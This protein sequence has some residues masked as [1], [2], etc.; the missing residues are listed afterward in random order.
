MNPSALRP[1]A[2]YSPSVR[3]ILRRRGQA[4]PGAPALR[5]VETSDRMALHTNQDS[6]RDSPK[7][8]QFGAAEARTPMHVDASSL[9]PNG[10]IAAESLV[11]TPAASRTET[12]GAPSAFQSLF[13]AQERHID[14]L[15]AETLSLHG[16]TLEQQRAKRALIE[17]SIDEKRELEQNIGELG[18]R[19]AALTREQR[20]LRD[21]RAEI[22][23]QAEAER[24]RRQDGL[25]LSEAQLRDAAARRAELEQLKRANEE[26]N[27]VLAQEKKKVSDEKK[28]LE[29]KLE[30]VEEGLRSSHVLS[31]AV[32]QRIE[33]TRQLIEKSQRFEQQTA[34]TVARA[35]D[36][37]QG[38]ITQA[39]GELQEKEE[40]IGVKSLRAS[41]LGT[42]HRHQ[43]AQFE[44]EAEMLRKQRAEL[45][46]ERTRLSTEL[47][48]LEREQNAAEADRTREIN[49]LRATLAETESAALAAQ[50]E[51]EDLAARLETRRAREA[52]LH[53]Q[54]HAQ[55]EEF[56][57]SAQSVSQVRDTEAEGIESI[58]AAQADEIQKL[59]EELQHAQ[60]THEQLQKEAAEADAPSVTELRPETQ[61][62]L[63][64]NT[65]LA[66]AEAAIDAARQD[67]K[68]AADEVAAQTQELDEK[69]ARVA[70]DLATAFDETEALE[71]DSSAA[72]ENERAQ[73]RA[74]R[75]RVSELEAQ[76]A[77][78]KVETDGIVTYQ[79]EE[80]SGASL[81]ASELQERGEAR[82]EEMRQRAASLR[83]EVVASAESLRAM[84]TEVSN[85][86]DQLVER[87]RA[88]ETA[89]AV[90]REQERAA[91]EM[92]EEKKREVAALEEQR[93]SEE[94]ALAE[95]Q[96]RVR[97]LKGEIKELRGSQSKAN[98]SAV[99]VTAERDA[100]KAKFEALEADFA[101][102]R[103][104]NKTQQ[105]IS[106]IE[107][108][109]LQEEKGLLER[110]LTDEIHA[111][112]AALH[113]SRDQLLLLRS[114]LKV[115][116]FSRS[117]V[118]KKLVDAKETSSDLSRM[119]Q[120]E[121]ARNA[122]MLAKLEARLTEL[123]R[124]ADARSQEKL[125]ETERL[126]AELANAEAR[127]AELVELQAAEKTSF[128]KERRELEERVAALQGEVSLHEK[129]AAQ[130]RDALLKSDEAT[131][132]DRLQLEKDTSALGALVEQRAAEKAKLE[133]IHTGLLATIASGKASAGDKLRDLTDSVEA[134]SARLDA[135]RRD[136][137]AKEE[138]FLS[139]EAEIQ[140]ALAAL[141]EI[142]GERE[143]WASEYSE[144]EGL[145]SEAVETLRTRILSISQYSRAT[146]QQCRML[147][148]EVCDLEQ[149][150]TRLTAQLRE[151]QA[152]VDRTRNALEQSA[153]EGATHE[154]E[155]KAREE[156]LQAALSTSRVE[157]DEACTAFK[158]E[159]ERLAMEKADTLAEIER[160]RAE[161]DEAKEH[162]QRLREK[163]LRLS[164][165]LSSSHSWIEGLE[166]SMSELA[167]VVGAHARAEE[168]LQAQLEKGELEAE[169]I[170]AQTAQKEKAAAVFERLQISCAKRLAGLDAEVE[171]EER[172]AAELS[173]RLDALNASLAELRREKED[174]SE[175]V[176][177]QC[178]QFQENNEELA[179][180]V[181]ERLEALRTCGKQ[182]DDLFKETRQLRRL[183]SA[184]VMRHTSISISN[185]NSREAL[186]LR[187]LD[188]RF[189]GQLS[190]AER[191]VEDALRRSQDVFEALAAG[192]QAL[193]RDRLSLLN[194]VDA[195]HAVAAQRARE[196]DAEL[197]EKIGLVRQLHLC[198]EENTQLINAATR[199]HKDVVQE[200]LDTKACVPGAESGAQPELEEHIAALAGNNAV[201]ASAVPPAPPRHSVAAY[202]PVAHAAM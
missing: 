195:A 142:D 192:V 88:R 183:F 81:Q 58:R 143:R 147:E 16:E 127:R 169:D 132:F 158:R 76:I 107:R 98:L 162:M 185:H 68:R 5:P 61:A 1:L 92:E 25:A 84:Q 106:G 196:A 113:A 179:A 125:Q 137:E 102:L 199:Y 197:A 194:E 190:L 157:A 3:R 78:T 94:G 134:L 57:L 103:Q 131:R 41:S 148:T 104:R 115:T 152:E 99:Q 35:T 44:Q 23:Q 67:E 198:S 168:A 97:A 39:R 128:A 167:R 145:V 120:E 170:R 11:E 174:R 83:L 188:E 40:T 14:A 146:E 85:L 177:Q 173:R 38:S 26:T 45:L 31:A 89:A 95:L 111:L 191:A 46:S 93:A 73:V 48:D 7:L 24:A 36:E 62:L 29:E 77:R 86:Q 180:Q 90:A 69:L 37:L 171:A 123:Q 60:S 181:R 154:A 33:S 75:S 50:A 164:Q 119:I 118:G 133:E 6:T 121:E 156:E 186:L 54:L 9:S 63:A 200:L 65:R 56:R 150:S 19:L 178:A 161:C 189:R 42:S 114:H 109:A 184:A 135:T 71:K 163:S 96:E 49:E 17:R 159:E 136:R 20:G 87:R 112:R 47:E 141:E 201:L 175:G 165:R 28:R 22:M 10:P 151:S 59:R 34:A 21:S 139:V 43:R 130:H 18:A 108:A 160:Q 202:F 72:L 51:A 15:H 55:E 149:T 80:L 32:R 153:T 12:Q 52:E 91:A 100:L 30:T 172:T 79:S 74:L 155:L 176:L 144:R 110:R 70:A 4:S 27:L 64:L 126:R 8:A 117:S 193:E 13:S 187:Q 122:A 166:Q 116:Q 2:N 140:E 129:H 82:I 66:N 138:E 101:A 53:A 105:A 124:D 182:R